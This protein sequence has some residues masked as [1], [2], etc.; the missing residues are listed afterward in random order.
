VELKK[1]VLD[2]AATKTAADVQVV[3]LMKKLRL[4][5]GGG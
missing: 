1:L 4:S 2:A 5:V 3:P